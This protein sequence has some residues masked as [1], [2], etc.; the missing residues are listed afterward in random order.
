MFLKI[1]KLCTLTHAFEGFEEYIKHSLFKNYLKVKI[2]L[3]LKVEISLILECVLA[4]IS[5][6]PILNAIGKI[7]TY[8]YI[9]TYL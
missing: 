7:A 1:M 3:S 8:M 5:I 4:Y 9:F 2:R 6:V